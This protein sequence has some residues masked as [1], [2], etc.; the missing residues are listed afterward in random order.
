MFWLRRKFLVWVVKMTTPG[1][2]GAWA[3]RPGSSP[4]HPGSVKKQPDHHP[5]YSALDVKCRGL[6]EA[7]AER[8][9]AG[10]GAAV[11]GGGAGAVASH[12]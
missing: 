6:R 3:P 9:R 5:T 11:T 4:P 7:A 2:V 8:S 12:E 1:V 10:A